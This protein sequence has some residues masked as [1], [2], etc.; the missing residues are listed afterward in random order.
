MIPACRG[1]LSLCLFLGFGMLLF[2]I[3][4]LS[5]MRDLKEEK[6]KPRNRTR[7]S[8]SAEFTVRLIGRSP[9]ENGHRYIIR[10]V[11]APPYLQLPVV[12][13]K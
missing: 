6:Q 3:V 5:K 9:A 8:A 2:E 12:E 10:L 4:H 7:S 1:R 13:R 11:Q